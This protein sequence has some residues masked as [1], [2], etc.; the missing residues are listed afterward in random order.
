LRGDGLL[1]RFEKT[2]TS[3]TDVSGVNDSHAGQN[4]LA[5]SLLAGSS[6]GLD[7][8]EKLAAD[9]QKAADYEKKSTCPGEMAEA[10][11]RNRRPFSIDDLRARGN[12]GRPHASG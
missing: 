10:P 11:G 2:N 7:R 12:L 8:P 5:S 6:R 3:A 1:H 9:P 4:M